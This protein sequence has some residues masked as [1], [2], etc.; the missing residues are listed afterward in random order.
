MYI[1]FQ[2]RTTKSFTFTISKKNIPPSYLFFIAAL[3]LPTLPQ[4][5]PK[6]K[7]RPTQDSIITIKYRL[8]G[9]ITTCEYN[10]D[11]FSG[12]KGAAFRNISILCRSIVLQ[13][14]SNLLLPSYKITWRHLS[15]AMG[16][17]EQKYLITQRNT[18]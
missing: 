9:D 7:M 12:A 17:E 18:K 15:S 16:E 13:S 3:R 8:A 5:I 14:S 1:L 11:K 4:T 10:S 6:T 2:Q